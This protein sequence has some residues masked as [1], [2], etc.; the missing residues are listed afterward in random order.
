L[1]DPRLFHLGVNRLRE[2]RFG[3]ADDLCASDFKKC[4]QL[5]GGVF[6]DDGIMGEIFQNL[7]ATAFREIGGDEDEMQF[8]F[9][10][11]EG[12]AS[13][14]QDARFQDEGEKALDGFGGQRI[15]H[16]YRE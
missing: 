10:A 11:T 16:I 12:V 15:R 7:R 9:A 3:E 5:G 6:L 13:D 14:Q 2:I 4:I 1:I 8:A